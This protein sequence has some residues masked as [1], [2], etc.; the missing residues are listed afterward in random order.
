LAQ[1]TCEARPKGYASHRKN[2]GKGTLPFS[3]SQRAGTRLVVDE[4]QVVDFPWV[5]TSS[6]IIGLRLPSAASGGCVLA[7]V[8]L[9]AVDPRHRVPGPPGPQLIDHAEYKKHGRVAPDRNARI[10]FFDADQGHLVD[11]GS[12]GRND[13]WNAAPPARIAD[14]MAKLPQRA[15]SG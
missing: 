13:Q 3:E 2:A 9:P 14:V 4:Q 5:I 1:A 6:S 15:A 12:P 10:A 8:L 7:T 11:R